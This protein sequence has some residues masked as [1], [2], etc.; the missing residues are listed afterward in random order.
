MLRILLA[1]L[2]A[3]A[4]AGGLGTV[5][6]SWS[7]SGDIVALGQSMSLAERA[8]MA[9]GDLAAL[10]PRYAALIGAGALV[11]YPLALLFGRVA[12]DFRTLMLVCAGAI[13]VLFALGVLRYILGLPSFP[14]A[15]TPLGVITQAGFGALAGYVFTLICPPGPARAGP[16]PTTA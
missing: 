5:G 8:A 3:I 16:P 12:P 1:L 11:A 10:G 2:V 6:S 4:I 7:A 9:G 15:R 14:G 13:S